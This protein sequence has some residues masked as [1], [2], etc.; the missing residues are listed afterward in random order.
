MERLMRLWA[1]TL[2]WHGHAIVAAESAE[3]AVDLLHETDLA[4]DQRMGIVDAGYPNSTPWGDD[5]D[6]LQVAELKLP[7]TEG[8]LAELDVD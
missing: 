7:E 2:S 5:R 8:I 4:E 3:R 6:H 1:V